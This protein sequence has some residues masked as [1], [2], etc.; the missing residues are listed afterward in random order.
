[1]H[2]NLNFLNFTFSGGWGRG[3]FGRREF[4]RLEGGGEERREL[5]QLLRHHV[6]KSQMRDAIR[7]ILISQGTVCV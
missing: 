3:E 4:G 2:E 5:L 6:I 1:M 7:G